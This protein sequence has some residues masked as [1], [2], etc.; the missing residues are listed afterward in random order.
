MEETKISIGMRAPPFCLPDSEEKEVC[1]ESFRG[2]NVVLYF[3]PK[4]NT[5]GCTAEA[6][7][8][9]R[10]KKEFE[11]ADTEVIGVSKDSPDSHRRFI[12]GKNLTITLLSDADAAVQKMYGV[13]KPLKFMGKEF[14]GTKRT[15]FLIGSDGRVRNIWDKV[16][17]SG[18]AGEVLGVCPL[19]I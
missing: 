14:L 16:D 11:G 18:H 9:S 6:E 7:G 12:E 8:F 2:K 4:D 17:V 13:W 5:P 10:L 3:Y 15:T 19:K 1:L